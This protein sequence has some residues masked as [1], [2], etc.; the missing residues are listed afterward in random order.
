MSAVPEAEII[1]FDSVA[2]FAACKRD[3]G[4]RIVLTNGCFDLLHPGH[5]AVLSGAAQMGDTLIVGVNNDQGVR[6]LKGAG[7]PVMALEDRLAMVCAL[8]WVDAVTAFEGDTADRLI[9]QVQPTFYVKGGDYD[10]RSGDRVL[11]E[12]ET[13]DRLGIEI[14]YVPLLAGHASSDLIDRSPQ[15]P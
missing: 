11:P 15:T 12:V 8:R 3:S 7:R 5:L 13:L 6:S 2:Q 9:E 4:G 10:P 1:R 14:A